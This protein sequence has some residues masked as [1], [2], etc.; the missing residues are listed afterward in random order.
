MKS[1][2]SIV[3]RLMSRVSPGSYL[4]IN[5]GTNVFHDQTTGDSTRARAV[6]LY[7]ASR[8]PPYH[9]R[10]PQW[11]QDFFVA[12]ATFQRTLERLLDPPGNREPQFAM[13]AG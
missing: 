7:A 9:L 8:A 2:G 6:A 4:V 5:D 1:P 12:P 13:A 10:T 11:I 3:A